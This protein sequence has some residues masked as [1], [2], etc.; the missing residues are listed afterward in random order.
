MREVRSRS[1]RRREGKRGEQRRAE[2]R[3]A[4]ES[5]GEQRRG[6]RKVSRWKEGEGTTREEEYRFNVSDIIWNS[7][8]LPRP[9][10]SSDVMHHL[11]TICQLIKF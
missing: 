3:R 7:S 1:E 10:C 8:S 11:C 6:E 5:G 9:F 2:E 4:E